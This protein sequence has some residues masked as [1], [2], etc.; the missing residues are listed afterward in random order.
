[1][2]DKF[3]LF[4]RIAAALPFLLL[5]AAIPMLLVAGLDEDFKP[6]PNYRMVSSKCSSGKS[7]SCVNKYM[8]YKTFCGQ[9]MQPRVTTCCRV[10]CGQNQTTY[11]DAKGN[12]DDC[13]SQAFAQMPVAIG[14]LALLGIGLFWLLAMWGMCKAVPHTC[15]LNY[16]LRGI[17]FNDAAAAAQQVAAKS[18]AGGEEAI[19]DTT[20][21]DT[22]QPN[23]FNMAGGEEV[24]VV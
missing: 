24:Q 12:P 22:V 11:F 9:T 14:G 2:V 5:V 6:C 3:L 17:G 19:A 18:S 13:Y 21:A 20:D 10:P 15:N 4:V 23:P 8:Q 16:V 1:M 7:K